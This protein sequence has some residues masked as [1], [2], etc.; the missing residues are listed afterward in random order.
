MLHKCPNLKKIDIIASD[1]GKPTQLQSRLTLTLI[2]V[3]DSNNAAQ[4]NRMQICLSTHAFQCEKDYQSVIIK[5]QEEDAKTSVSLRLAK[6]NDLTKSDEDICYYLSGTD[7]DYFKLDKRSAVLM[8]KKRL[9]REKRDEYELIVK[10]SEYCSCKTWDEASEQFKTPRDV[11]KYLQ[12][13]PSQCKL[14]NLDD[15]TFNLNDISQLKVKVYI[16]DVNDNSPKFAKSFYQVAITADVDYGETILESFV[17][18]CYLI[19]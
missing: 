10:A 11:R 3:D 14:M 1:L 15:D 19:L 5:M 7:R 8:P 17:S 13:Q 9:D 4:F 18:S 6:M 12:N 16:Q 2:L